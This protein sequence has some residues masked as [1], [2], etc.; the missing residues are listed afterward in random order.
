MFFVAQL[1]GLFVVNQYA[2]EITQVIDAEGKIINI[3]SYNLP[4]GLDP[5]QDIEPASTLVS[6]A[7]AIMI[8]VI[9]MFILMKYNAET[10][11]RFWFFIVTVLAIG[12][13]VNSLILKIPYS[14]LIALIVALPLA[15]FKIFKRNLIVH[16]LTELI[17]Y[18]IGRAHV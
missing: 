11:L 6:I 1:I 17:I 10:L 16:N 2:P 8:A 14:A 13:T 15:F 9:L 3:T 12:I 18:Q 4:Y 7:I 5:P